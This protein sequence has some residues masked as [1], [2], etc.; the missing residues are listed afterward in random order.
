MPLRTCL[1]W[2]S[3]ALLCVAAACGG[4]KPVAPS[5]GPAARLDAITDLI[6]SAPVGTPLTDGIVVRVTDVSGR[7]VAGAAVALAVTLGNGATSPRVA[8]TDAKGQAT[9]LW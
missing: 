9:A 4:D 6:R 3:L 5:S 8:L 2:R 7:P 1:R